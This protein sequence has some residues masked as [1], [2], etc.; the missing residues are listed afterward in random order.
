MPPPA[1]MRHAMAIAWQIEFVN[2]SRLP[3]LPPSPSSAG[4]DPK[5]QLFS[6]ARRARA[7]SDGNLMRACDTLGSITC[8]T[9]ADAECSVRQ[10]SF[11][12]DQ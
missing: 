8:N 5:W 3:S 4:G 1:A 9:I 10:L 2:H 12:F 6:L 11:E 7:P